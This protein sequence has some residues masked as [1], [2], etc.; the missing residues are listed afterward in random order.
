VLVGN[1]DSDALR[2]HLNNPG[3]DADGT[4]VDAPG[5]SVIGVIAE[6]VP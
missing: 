2:I 5:R 3:E 1:R 6:P 4:G